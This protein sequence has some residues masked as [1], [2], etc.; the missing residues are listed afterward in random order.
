MAKMQ[1]WATWIAAE[2]DGERLVLLYG[3]FNLPGELFFRNDFGDSAPN[4]VHLLVDWREQLPEDSPSTSLQVR[5]HEIKMMNH[6]SW[7]RSI[8]RFMSRWAIAS[9]LSYCRFPRAS[10]SST[11]A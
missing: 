3:L 11:F 2:F 8:S 7:R 5:D 9:R 4:Y 10:A 1:I 6:V